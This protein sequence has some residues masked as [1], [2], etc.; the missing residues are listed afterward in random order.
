[1]FARR[2]PAFALG[3]IL[4]FFAT[5]VALG[6]GE[7]VDAALHAADDYAGFAEKHAGRAGQHAYRALVAAK[8]WDYDKFKKELDEYNAEVDIAAGFAAAAADAMGRARSAAPGDPALAHTQEQ[9]NDQLNT[10]NRDLKEAKKDIE[11]AIKEIEKCRQ[12]GKITYV[13]YEDILK[14]KKKVFASPTPVGVPPCGSSG[15]SIWCF[16][17]SPGPKVSPAPEPSPKLKRFFFI[18]PRPVGGYRMVYSPGRCSHSAPA[19]A[20][21][22]GNGTGSETG[23]FVPPN[24]GAGPQAAITGTATAETGQTGP[25]TIIVQTVDAAGHRS[26][27]QGV[28]DALGK[29]GFF[30]P[31]GARAISVFRHFDRNGQPDKVDTG[32]TCRIT[33]APGLPPNLQELTNRP[34]NGPAVLAANSAYELGG[35]GQGMVQLQTRAI[36]PLNAQ[37]QADGSTATINTLGASDQS[38]IGKWRDDTPLGLHHVSISSDGQVSNAFSTDVVTLAFAKM[39]PLH[40]GNTYDETLAIAGVE[41]NS[42]ARVIFV[43]GGAASFA[44]GSTTATMLVEK[45]TAKA[46]IRINGPGQFNLSARLLVN[47]PE[48]R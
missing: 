24:S 28:T 44:D 2:L 25:S 43:V 45:G 47:F 36:N 9:V 30:V 29:F 38:V 11:D 15:G 3:G 32:A 23:I 6:A 22:P 34:A 46:R 48:F 1:M 4:I 20:A 17:G 40:P 16:G 37:L 35:Q 21:M 39:P 41:A 8:K 27:F 42:T 5:L 31:A 26:F 12:T 10:A 33:N 18:C 7:N 13:Q 19:V 14:Q